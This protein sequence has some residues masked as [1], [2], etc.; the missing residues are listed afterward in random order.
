MRK[1]ILAVMLALVPAS[2]A[3]GEWRITVPV[4]ISNVPAELDSFT[5]MCEVYTLNRAQ[6][7]GN[8]GKTTALVGG[9]YRGDVVVPVSVP[10]M[11]PALA[12]EYSCDLTLGG[13]KGGRPHTAENQLVFFGQDYRARRDLPLAAGA[14]LTVRGSF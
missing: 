11:N 12:K 3:A 7:L 1:S 10:G 4:E 2:V 6:R 9:A 14:V 5:V 13:W 8:A